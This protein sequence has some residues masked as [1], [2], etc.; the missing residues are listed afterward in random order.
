MTGYIWS[1]IVG[2]ARQRA[3]AVKVTIQE[4]WQL[5]LSQDRRCALTGIEIGFAPSA[6]RPNGTASLDRIDSSGDYEIGN[7]QWVHKD[8]N[9]MKRE[10]SQDRFFEICC[11]VVANKRMA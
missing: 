11:L 5:Y 9:L 6:C 4:A 10:M 1:R 7:I 3:I 8:V 2:F